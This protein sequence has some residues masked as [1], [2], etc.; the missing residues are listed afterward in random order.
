[1][2]VVGFREPPD[3]IDCIFCANLALVHPL[4]RRRKFCGIEPEKLFRQIPSLLI[5][6]ADR[7][8]EVIKRSHWPVFSVRATEIENEAAGVPE[9]A[10]DFACKGKKPVNIS[11]LVEVAIL[12]LPLQCEWRGGDHEVDAFVGQLPQ[13]IL[14]VAD[15]GSPHSRRV[16]RWNT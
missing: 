4:D 2:R 15:V 6:H 8:A 5:A 7:Y 3:R 13:Q 11:S 14:R 16:K 1:M 9:N 10:F 12:F